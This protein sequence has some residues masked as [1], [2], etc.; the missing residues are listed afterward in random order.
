[1]YEQKKKIVPGAL[2]AMFWGISSIMALYMF[3]W[4]AS[5]VGFSKKAAAQKLY[6]ENPNEWNEKSLN[7]LRTAKTCSTIGLWV[8]IFSTIMLILYIVFIVSMVSHSY[9]SPYYY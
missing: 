8:S 3:G 1:M 5:I 9:Y 6:D 2:S 7:I 4:V